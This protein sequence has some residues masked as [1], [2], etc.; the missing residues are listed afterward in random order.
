MKIGILGVGHLAGYLVPGLLREPSFELLLSPRNAEKAAALAARYAV[1]V[2]PSAEALVRDSAV[3]LLAV[4]PEKAPAAVENLP[5]REEQ[6][7]VSLCAGVPLGSLA[8]ARP[9]TLARAM[10]TTAASIGQSPTALW[11]DLPAARQ[12]I[13]PLG[14]VVALPDE[15]AFESATVAAALYGWLQGL[16]GE[17]TDWQV[18]AG[19]PPETARGLVAQTAKAAAAIIQARPETSIELLTRDVCTPGGITELGLEHLRRNDAFDPWHGA[20][21]AVLERLRKPRKP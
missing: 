16:V 10:P 15:T 3:V 17:M 1:T 6:T 20:C 8:A 11:P 5:W 4:P 19:L 12:A 2:M 13:E 14:P 18:A 21:D 7:L 9:A